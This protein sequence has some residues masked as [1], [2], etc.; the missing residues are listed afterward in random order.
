MAGVT[1]AFESGATTEDVMHV[2]RW[3][4]LDIALG[5][6]INSSAFKLCMA[7]KVPSLLPT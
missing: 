4:T 6:K 7:G 3:Q 2:G 5:Y 1:A